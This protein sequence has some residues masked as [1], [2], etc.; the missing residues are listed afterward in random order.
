MFMPSSYLSFTIKVVKTISLTYILFGIHGASGGDLCEI[1]KRDGITYLKTPGQEMAIVSWQ[2]HS[3][4]D[5]ATGLST[6]IKAS[7][8]IASNE[9]S[10]AQTHLAEY[11]TGKDELLNRINDV[12][13]KLKKVQDR[14][15]VQTIDYELSHVEA[16]RQEDMHE[17]MK[18]MYNEFER[19]CSQ[20]S[21][22]NLLTNFRKIQDGP[23]YYFAYQQPYPVKVEGIESHFLRTS[24]KDCVSL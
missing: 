20:K 23:A 22:G 4:E 10:K 12:L 18:K 2:H 21:F 7:D 6:L 17:M 3:E 13:S 19:R 5:V 9:C 15:A 1:T 24:F 14:F 16:S 8:L 11:L